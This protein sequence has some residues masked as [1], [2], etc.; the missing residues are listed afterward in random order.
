MSWL[1]FSTGFGWLVPVVLYA[2]LRVCQFSVDTIHGEGFYAATEWPQS[3]ATFVSAFL[4]GTLGYYLN[5][6][7]RRDLV[8]EETGEVVGKALPHT[9]LFIPVEI[10]AAIALMSGPMA[11]IDWR[12]LFL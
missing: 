2:T 3:L 9:L 1:A 12:Q 8:D 5:H 4:L 7:K 6:V 10:W 11:P